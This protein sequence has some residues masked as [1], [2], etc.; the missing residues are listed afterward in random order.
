M[1]QSDVSAVLQKLPR[2]AFTVLNSDPCLV[3]GIERGVPGYTPLRRKHNEAKARAFADQMNEGVSRAQLEAMEI[4]SMFG[5]HVP[6]AD[7][8]HHARPSDSDP[9]RGEREG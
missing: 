3:I 8:D 5:W 1:T 6:G 2:Y 7:P 4:G 9:M